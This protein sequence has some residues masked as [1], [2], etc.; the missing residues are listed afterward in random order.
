MFLPWG[1]MFSAVEVVLINT[2]S[3]KHSSLHIEWDEMGK[4]SSIT[5]HL[6]VRNYN[7][8]VE[9]LV[10]HVFFVMSWILSA[11]SLCQT[12]RP[13]QTIGIYIVETLFG[14]IS[15]PSLAYLL[16][17]ANKKCTICC[18]N[19]QKLLEFDFIPYMF[20]SLVIN[21]SN[22]IEYT[23]MIYC[24][25][26]HSITLNLSSM[27]ILTAERCFHT[28]NIHLVHVGCIAGDQVLYTICIGD[29]LPW[30]S[31]RN[32]SYGEGTDST[33]SNGDN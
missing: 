24:T 23:Q 21:I 2:S 1:L 29:C 32:I 13:D 33:L 9:W 3:Q 11:L 15:Y 4:H 18:G 14:T 5:L 27:T 19:S 25:S 26:D 20:N 17:H 7:K 22:L 12:L 6:I 8:V 10:W 28:A 30:K 31:I 16:H